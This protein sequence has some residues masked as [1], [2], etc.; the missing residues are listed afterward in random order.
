M[1]LNMYEKWWI[2]NTDSNLTGRG[3]KLVIHVTNNLQH[4]GTTIHWH[5][6]RQLGTVEYG[7]WT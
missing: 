2:S 5:G 3:D 6:M 1:I 7:S 4:N